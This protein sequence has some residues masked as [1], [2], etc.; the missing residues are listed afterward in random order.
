MTSYCLLFFKVLKKKEISIILCLSHVDLF[1]ISHIYEYDVE[2][3]IVLQ[4]ATR[5]FA[6]KKK[7]LK[8]ITMPN[9]DCFLKYL[10]NLIQ[11]ELHMW[12]LAA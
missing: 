4:D 1:F 11:F 9:R 7:T 10:I 8:F 2:I 3:T 6:F 5:I 12:Y